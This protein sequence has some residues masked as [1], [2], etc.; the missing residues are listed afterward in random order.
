[1]LASGQDR[2][3]APAGSECLATVTRGPAIS[4]G[5]HEQWQVRFLEVRRAARV[6][7]LS[8]WL[9]Q[10]KAGQPYTQRNVETFRS[11]S[12]LPIIKDLASAL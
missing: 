8:P 1:M 7:P 11:T 12:P 2:G 6:V 9:F 3:R 4:R 5:C 10:T